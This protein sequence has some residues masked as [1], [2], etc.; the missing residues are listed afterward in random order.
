[1]AMP[2]LEV[3][4]LHW[5]ATFAVNV[6][7]AMFLTQA[8]ARQWA[9][10]PGGERRSRAVVNVSSTPSGHYGTPGRAAYCASKGALRGLQEPKMAS[11][12]CHAI[13]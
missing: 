9:A 13:L 8:V 10:A 11:I 12:V 1:M 6:R 3:T 5:D 7:G 4:P 2:F